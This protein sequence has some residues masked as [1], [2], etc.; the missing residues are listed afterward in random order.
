[1]ALLLSVLSG[2]TDIEGSFWNEGVGEN[3]FGPKGIDMRI[4]ITA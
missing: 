3:Y 2:R 4:G 1:L